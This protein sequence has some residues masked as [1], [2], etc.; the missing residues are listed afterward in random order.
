MVSFSKAMAMYL[1]SIPS[2]SRHQILSRCSINVWC[3]P[4]GELCN[5]QYISYCFERFLVSVSV[6]SR[7]EKTT[8]MRQLYGRVTSSTV[9]QG[10]EDTW[11]ERETSLAIPGTAWRVIW[12][13]TSPFLCPSEGTRKQIIEIIQ[14]DDKS[15]QEKGIFEGH[16]ASYFQMF[17]WKPCERV[18]LL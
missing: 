16:H 1:S 14:G 17:E 12:K 15:N 6:V 8:L 10:L 5:I 11:L 9:I 13:K 2:I 3:I 18:G 4:N 7:K